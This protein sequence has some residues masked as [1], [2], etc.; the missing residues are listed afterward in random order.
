M[1]SGW[2]YLAS[3]CVISVVGLA[4]CGGDTATEPAVEGTETTADRPQESAPARPP[5]PAA[6]QSAVAPFGPVP[7]ENGSVA[8]TPATSRIVFVGKHLDAAKDDRIGGFEKFTGSAKVAGRMLTSIE[9][10]IDVNSVFTFQEGLTAHLKNADFF[11]T[12][13]YANARFVSTSIADGTVTGELTLHGVTKEIT[14]PATIDVT[15]DGMRLKAEFKI[16]RFDFGMNGQKEGVASDVEMKIAVG[17][18]TNRDAI[19]N[20]GGGQGGGAGARMGGGRRGGNWDPMEMFARQDADKDGKLTGDEIPAQMRQFLQ[21]I[22]TDSD[23]SVSKEEIEAMGR[24]GRRGGGR[25]GAD[26][27]GNDRPQ[28]PGQ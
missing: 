24:G 3:V 13:E 2:K 14:F 25:G 28:R 21:R 9:V 11:E 26:K 12:N 18:P 1:K 8:I 27:G 22:D 20:G 19:I 4:G 16:N 7:I 6:N 10:E 15:E 23:G 17:S 5:R